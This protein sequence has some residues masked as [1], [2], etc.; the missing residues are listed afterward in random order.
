MN[1]IFTPWEWFCSYNEEQIE[2]L[3]DI[4]WRRTIRMPE[5]KKEINDD[6]LQNINLE[7]NKKSDK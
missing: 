6:L 3:R 4:S 5:I 7:A 2:M 1:D